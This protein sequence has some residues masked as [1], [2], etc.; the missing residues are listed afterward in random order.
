M[1]SSSK[2]EPPFGSQSDLWFLSTLIFQTVEALELA[3]LLS[4]ELPLAPEMFSS[5][6]LP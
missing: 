3:I 1:G 6:N 5:C 4:E 2:I